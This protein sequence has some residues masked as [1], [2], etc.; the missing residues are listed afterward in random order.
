MNLKPALILLAGLLIHTSHADEVRHYRYDAMQRLTGADYDGQGSIEYAYDNLGNR[1]V[2]TQQIGA[3][4][5]NQPP[6]VVQVIAPLDGASAVETTAP[7]L[8]WNPA[9]DPDAGDV[10]SYFLYLGET[11]TPFLIASGVKTYANICLSPDTTYFWQVNARDNHNAETPSPVWSFKT[12]ATGH[13]WCDLIEG[14]ETADAF[15]KLDWQRAQPTGNPGWQQATATAYV[16]TGAAASPQGLK[17]NQKASMA[18]K[19]KTVVGKLSFAYAVSSAPGDYLEFYVDGTRKGRWQGTIG[20][21][22]AI[23]P[24]TEGTH[25]FKWQYIKNSSGVAGEDRAWVDEILIPMKP[26]STF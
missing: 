16:G 18:I 7:T 13:A 25:M 15:D 17:N 22:Q 5:S 23:I 11:T 2:D 6:S 10:V 19:L 26:G 12:Q 1:L 3:I 20:W 9:T 8:S 4:P 24:V 21:T 14:F